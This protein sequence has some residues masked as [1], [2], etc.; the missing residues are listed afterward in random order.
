MSPAAADDMVQIIETER[1]KRTWT[2]TIF[3]SGSMGGTSVLVFAALHPERVDGVV[4]LGAATDIARYET[5]CR[6]SDSP[7]ATAGIR[8][9]IADAIAYAYGDADKTVHSASGNA[10]KLT[11]PIVLFHGEKD[12]L[13]PIEEARDLASKLKQA[14]HFIYREIS[15]GNHDSPLPL[16]SEAVN[17]LKGMIL[18]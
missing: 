2:K 9:A 4:A 13:I 15:G 12:T 14:P 1:Q 16:W 11:M 7:A 5:W 6:S 3:V 8:S 10:Q 17:L 18:K